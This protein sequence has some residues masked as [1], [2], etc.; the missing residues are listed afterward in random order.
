MDAENTIDAIRWSLA[1]SYDNT[2]DLGGPNFEFMARKIHE[3]FVAPSEAF[4]TA[5]Q[6]LLEVTTEFAAHCPGCGNSINTSEWGHEPECVFI[7]AVNASAR[8]GS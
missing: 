6:T 2:L 7:D 8:L 4:V 1:E 3:Q 5:A